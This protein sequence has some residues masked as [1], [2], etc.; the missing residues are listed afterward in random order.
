MTTTEISNALTLE[1]IP[2]LQKRVNE[3]I[4]EKENRII[5]IFMILIV[6]MLSAFMWLITAQKEGYELKCKEAGENSINVVLKNK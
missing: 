2:G 4:E 3:E 5:A 1:G 6:F